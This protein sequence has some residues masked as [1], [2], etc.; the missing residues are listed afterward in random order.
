MRWWTRGKTKR[1]DSDSSCPDING[2]KAASSGG[3]FLFHQDRWL[4]RHVEHLEI[5][6]DQVA[7]RRLTI[8]LDLPDAAE[9]VFHDDGST[10]WFLIPLARLGKEHVPSHIDLRNESGDAV[11][12]LTK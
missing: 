6:S 10:K 3:W 12:L 5:L 4:R 2:S 7:H 9:A 11:P 1:P 8:D